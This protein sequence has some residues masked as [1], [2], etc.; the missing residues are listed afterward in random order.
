MQDDITS[1]P[2]FSEEIEFK[3]IIKVIGVGGGGNNA[4]NHMYNQNIKGVSFVVCNTDLQALRASDVPTKVLLGPNITWSRS[5]Q[6]TRKG[7]IG[8]RREYR[9]NR[10]AI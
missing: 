9:R 5:W 10:Q 6:Y 2:G 7:K 4:I 1:N 8:C 3:K